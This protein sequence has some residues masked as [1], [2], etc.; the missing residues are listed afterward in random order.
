MHIFRVQW[1]WIFRANP[2]TDAISITMDEHMNLRRSALRAL[3]VGVLACSVVSMSHAAELKENSA[4]IRQDITI[5][6]MAVTIKR[7]GGETGCNTANH[8]KWDTTE[9]KCS[10][11]EYMKEN[12]QV[13]SIASADYRLSIGVN[14]STTLTANVRTKDGQLVGAG[15]PV[16]WSTSKGYLSA[17]SSI[18]NAA[19]QATVTLTTPKGTATGLTTIAATAK[20]GGTSIVVVVANSA[21]ITD[22]TASPP[23][24][25]ADGSSAITLI[26]T[27]TYF[28]N[29]KSV[30]AGEGLSWDTKIGKYTYA[31]TV[32][33]P[34]GQA[35][36]YLVSTEPGTNFA[37]AIKNVSKLKQVTFTS[38]AP[39]A[40]VI[41]AVSSTDQIGGDLYKVAARVSWSGENLSSTTTYKITVNIHPYCY[42]GGFDTSVKSVDLYPAPGSSTWVIDSKQE[43]KNATAMY[44]VNGKGCFKGAVLQACNGTSCSAKDFQIESEYYN[45]S[46]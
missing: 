24:A 9:G 34:N 25:L 7:P 20:G 4:D 19:S 16:T 26:A 44:E 18:T 43:D 33:N 5:P 38:P 31:E 42:F 15:V 36:A 23:T 10:N 13:V 12:A 32:T 29:G 39:V 1:I 37:S 6:G 45:Q 22:L 28:D 27:V 30:G 3:V 35:V 8:E 46:M 40:P 14:E 17:G 41:T 11:T 21:S 2:Q